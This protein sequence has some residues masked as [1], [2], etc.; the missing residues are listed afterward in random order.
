MH[1]DDNRTVENEFDAA[2]QQDSYVKVMERI[3]KDLERVLIVLWVS[4]GLLG[5]IAF[6]V[7]LR[8]LIGR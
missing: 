2:V 4:A 3:A 8:M 6:L 5:L 1:E 7:L